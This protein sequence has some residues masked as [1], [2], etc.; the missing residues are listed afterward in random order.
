M[1]ASLSEVNSRP[2]ILLVPL[3]SVLPIKQRAKPE[4]KS[5]A[6][7]FGNGYSSH[8]SHLRFDALAAPVIQRSRPPQN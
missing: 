7:L 3:T 5:I 6:A 2:S 8:Y 4:V 1:K